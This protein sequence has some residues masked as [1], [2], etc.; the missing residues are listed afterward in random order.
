MKKILASF[1][2]TVAIFMT[3]VAAWDRGGTLIDKVLLISLS[4]VIILGVHLIPAISRK[5]VAWLVWSFCLLCAVFG[6][7]TFL[8]NAS[9]RAGEV[10]AQQSATTVGTE[11]QISATKEALA[12]ITARPVSEVATQLAQ[13]R[14]WRVRSAL[15][16]ELADGKRA[17]GLQD[18]LVRLSAIHTASLQTGSSDPVIAGISA[19]TGMTTEGVTVTIGMA[20]ALLLELF[21]ALAWVEALRPVTEK[22]TEK[23][24]VTPVTLPVTPVTIANN[25]EVT[26][27][28]T[29]AVTT[30]VTHVTGV[31]EAVTDAITPE[32]VEIIE[33]VR[34]GSCPTTVGGIRKYLSC[35]QGKA[36]EL[37]RALIETK[38]IPA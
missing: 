11:R 8:T 34:A 18:E 3:S 13:E 7:I 35:S 29:E 21:G 24:T 5:P 32:V 17:E 16:T 25:Q 9:L 1:I 4:I 22:V 31:T 27:H 12:A 26:K 19:F 6:H 20:F 38:I 28:E 30:P 33:A 15:R 2:T 23:V 10:R 36:S 14:V 37:R